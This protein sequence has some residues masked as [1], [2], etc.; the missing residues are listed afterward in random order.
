MYVVPRHHLIPAALVVFAGRRLHRGIMV[1]LPGL[2]L[3]RQS[4]VLPESEPIDLSRIGQPYDGAV[5]VGV[6]EGEPGF[7]PL[8][9]PFFGA[10]S[11]A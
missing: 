10:A 4:I 11:P 9:F 3:C 1:R 6:G 8:A 7:A 5:S 2:P